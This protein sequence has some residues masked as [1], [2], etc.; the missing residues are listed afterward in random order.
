MP[1]VASSAGAARFICSSK[2]CRPC[3]FPL[4]APSMTDVTPL[5][6][7]VLAVLGFI[8]VSLGDYPAAHAHLGRLAAGQGLDQPC[9]VRFL[10]DEIEA[11]AALGETSLAE[12]HQRRLRTR[13]QAL[14]RP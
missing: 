8:A 12:A 5:M 9:V 14:R 13:G 6:S 7:S 4:S 2:R 11:L 3:I 10:P 1:A